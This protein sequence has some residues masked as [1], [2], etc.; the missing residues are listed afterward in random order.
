MHRSQKLTVLAVFCA[1]ALPAWAAADA[2][3]TFRVSKDGGSRITFVSDATLEK[4]TGVSSEVQGSLKVNPDDLSKVSGR[5]EAPVASFRTGIALRDQH[6]RS[7]KWLN[8]AKNPN[9]IFEVQGV[10]GASKL[11]KGKTVNF[12][13]HGR[14]TMNGVTRPVVADARA[15]FYARDEVKDAPGFDG[16]VIRGRARFKLTLSEHNVSI[17]ATVRLKVAN[18]ITVTVDVRAAAK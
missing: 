10:S 6:L 16:D 4:I 9:V 15:R 1:L 5:L 11:E 7:D 3:R 14:A 12:K 2:H 18:D 17:P 8:A 13:I